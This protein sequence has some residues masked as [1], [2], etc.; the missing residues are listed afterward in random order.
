MLLLSL[1]VLSGA[2]SSATVYAPVLTPSGA[3]PHYGGMTQRQIDL[4]LLAGIGALLVVLLVLAL[5]GAPAGGGDIVNPIGGAAADPSPSATRLDNAPFETPAGTIGAP[6][7]TAPTADPPDSSVAAGGD[8]AL[9][10]TEPSVTA[11][12]AEEPPAEGE[13]VATDAVAEPQNVADAPTAEGEEASAATTSTA[14]SEPVTTGQALERVGFAFVTGSVGACGVPLQPWQH[15]AVS[16]DLL[17]RYGC[18]A[19]VEVTLSESVAGRE[20]VVAQIGDTMGAEI[21]GTVN[22]FVGPDEPALEYGVLE[23]RLQPVGSP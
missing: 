20:R 17:D 5:R 7:T 13:G 22:I 2:T 3:S 8:G 23:G 16:R 9:V 10:E 11:P 18:G 4:A 21:T 12:A 19:S 15:V 14:A 6:P 1:K